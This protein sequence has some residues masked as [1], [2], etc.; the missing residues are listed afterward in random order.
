MLEY[1]SPDMTED[2]WSYIWSLRDKKSFWF[3]L[4]T[5][6]RKRA[7]K[8]IET[9]QEETDLYIPVSIFNE[10]DT[11]NQRGKAAQS[12]GIYGLWLDID[13]QCAMRSRSDL[14][15]TV[16]DAMKIL[17]Q[18][19]FAPSLLINSGYGLQAWW[20]FKE[21][22][23]FDGPEERLQAS[24]LAGAWNEW[25]RL[26]ALRY[27]WGLDCVSDLAR[28]M[29]IPN[30][31]NCKGG[32]HVPVSILQDTGATYDPA[33]LEEI[34]PQEAWEAK[35][36]TSDPSVSVNIIVNPEAKLPPQFTALCANVEHFSTTWTHKKKIS[37]SSN[38]G[39]DLAIA[40][41]AA[42]ANLS[43]QAICDLLV[44]HAKE[45]GFPIK[46]KG[47]YERTI[48]KAREGGQLGLKPEETYTKES[49]IPKLHDMNTAGRDV[50]Y[51]E[52]SSV[53]SLI[54]VLLGIQVY[55]FIA[56]KTDPR[57]YE[58][59]T[60]SGK[61][62]FHKGQDDLASANT[63]R[64][65]IGDITR[66]YPP[67]FKT[68]D[69][70]VILQSLSFAAREVEIG[71][72]LSEEAQTKTWVDSYLASHPPMPEEHMT[73]AIQARKPFKRGDCIYLWLDELRSWLQARG[74]RLQMQ[75]LG[76]RMQRIGSKSCK[77]NYI[78]ALGLRTSCR[79]WE[80]APLMPKPEKEADE[81]NDD[82]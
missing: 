56:Y 70:D 74:E 18:S 1:I 52:R 37:D 24:R 5:G 72:D 3:Q 21:P 28:V 63:F 14:P 78:G 57:E 50:V 43:D 71:T 19:S 81:D 47:Y 60:E 42:M 76:A 26:Y 68:G 34:L 59:Y 27:G 73:E 36:G 46:R 31:F 17:E 48:A 11:E 80:I 75:K 33:D 13:V 2:K 29:R 61:V 54:S 7:R 16:T 39:Y 35:R 23:I 53:F 10:P 66:L 44:C 65:R 9:K 8:Y 25:F 6:G 12:A 64:K 67:R 58:L 38:S 40:S 69:W 22:W 41:Y 45:Q 4:D 79:A 62:F 20:L 30:T 15:P 51:A 55:D 82:E 77:V 49:I 32:F